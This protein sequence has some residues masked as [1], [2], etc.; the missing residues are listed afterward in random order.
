[1]LAGILHPAGEQAIPRMNVCARVLLIA[2]AQG[3]NSTIEEV[4]DSVQNH[5]MYTAAEMLIA[6]DQASDIGLLTSAIMSG[7]ADT[8][9]MVRKC[10]FMYA[11]E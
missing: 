3:W 1:M 7:K 10:V 4:V 11:Y 2:T 9:A 8:V 6:T 5:R